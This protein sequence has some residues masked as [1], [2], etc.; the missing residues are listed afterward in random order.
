MVRTSPFFDVLDA[1]RQLFSSQLDL[2]EAIRDRFTATADLFK[3]LGGGWTDNSD[4]LTPGL[5]ATRDSYE[6]ADAATATPAGVSE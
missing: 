3:A 5:E 4:S 6:P 1:Q 2:A